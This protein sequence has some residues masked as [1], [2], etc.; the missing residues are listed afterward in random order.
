MKVAQQLTP[1]PRGMPLGGLAKRAPELREL[2]YFHSV[3]RAGNFGRAA[4]ELNIAQPTVTHQVQKLEEGLGTQ[5]LIRHGRGVTLTQAGACLLDRLDII[6][7]LLEAPLEEAVSPAQTSGTMS[8]ALPP[9]CA[10]LL[11]PPLI[12]QCEARWSGLT[13]SIREADSASLEE[14]VMAGRVDVAILQDPPALDGLQ[15]EPVLSE[16]I[17]LVVGLRSPLADGTGPVRSR[18]LV[19]VPLILPD[20]RHWVRRRVENAWFRRGLALDR[21]QQVDSVALTKEMVRNGLGC[22]VLPQVAVQEEIAR[23]S[24]VFRPIDQMPLFAV[25]AIA[26][27][28]AAAAAPVIPG[29]A[30]ALRDVMVGLAFQELWP[31]A[32]VLDS[33][34]KVPKPAKEEMTADAAG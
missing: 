13:L 24:L 33:A 25:H 31:G 4:R 19:G 15:I 21:V 14:W 32:A 30:R 16:R 26:W 18:D 22:T 3:A 12:E 5:L 7:H 20:P 34:A 10:P 11:V 1:L 27:R 8:L 29:F 23:G 9:E 6:M 28:I 17:G 2:R